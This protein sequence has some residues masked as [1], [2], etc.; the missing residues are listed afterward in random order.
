MTCGET[1]VGGMENV[2]LGSFRKAW[3][4][5]VAR[6]EIFTH[7]GRTT[8][9]TMEVAALSCGESW[10]KRHIASVIGCGNM[11]ES[12]IREFWSSQT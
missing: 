12:V 5:S 6:K 10:R 2:C 3:S 1:V 8:F 7:P 4:A 11:I 9:F